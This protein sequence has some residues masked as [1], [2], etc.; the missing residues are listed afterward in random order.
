ML[1]YDMIP[2]LL[3]YDL[4]DLWWQSKHEC[5]RRAVAHLAI[6]RST[7]NDLGRFFPQLARES[8]VVA[9][10]GADSSFRPVAPEAIDAFREKYGIRKP[11]FLMVGMRGGYKGGATFLE[12]FAQLANRQEFEIICTGG[13]SQLEPDLAA[14]AD[15]HQIPIRLLQLPD[16]DDMCA[17]YA[18]ATALVYPSAYEG[19]GLPVLEAMACGCPVITCR[20]SS[21][22]EVGGEA[23][24]YVEHGDAKALT[25]ALGQVQDPVVRQRLVEAGFQQARLFS[26]KGMAEIVAGTISAAVAQIRQ[27]PKPSGVVSPPPQILSTLASSGVTLSFGSQATSVVPAPVCYVDSLRDLLQQFQNRPQDPNLFA[28][29]CR[30]R[31]MLAARLLKIAPSQLVGFHASDV[32]QAHQLLRSSGFLQFP[33]PTEDGGL[34]QNLAQRLVDPAAINV[35]LA[36]MLYRPAHR[37]PL[38]VLLDAS[39]DWFVKDHLLYVLACP[40]LFCG[41]GEAAAYAEYLQRW[42]EYLHTALAPDTPRTRELLSV[43]VQ[44]C[45]CIGAYFNNANLRSLYTHRAELIS[46]GLRRFGHR[47][48]HTFPARRAGSKIRLGILNAHWT[49]ATETYATLPLFEHLD[50]AS[51]EVTLFSLSAT[52]VPL[53]QYCRSRADHFVVLPEALD[54]QVQTL[55]QHDLDVLFF[56]TNLTAVSHALT[57]IAMHRLARVQVT[58]ICSPATTGMPMIDCFLA[59]TLTEPKPDAQA[60]YREKLCLIEGPGLCFNYGGKPGPTGANVTRAA[61]GLNDQQVLFVSGANFFKII[62]E[63]RE[64]WARIL[65]AVPDAVLLLYPFGPAWSN[66]YAVVPF[67]E[68][69]QATLQRHGVASNRVQ[70]LRPLPTSSDIA[71]FLAQCDIYLDS[72]PYAGATSLLDPLSVGLPPVAM[73]GDCLRLAQATAVLTDLGL[74]ELVAADVESYVSLAVALAQDPAR[75]HALRQAIVG[76]MN[77]S[78]PPRF[79]DSQWFSGQCGEIFR[80]LVRERGIL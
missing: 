48:D 52:N 23:V 68:A 70:F 28:S 76:R 14:P 18:G 56:G 57:L 24:I 5:I 74:P 29:L 30:E 71:Q 20:A 43:F 8:V 45:N 31:R 58:S 47:L 55:R 21:I 12:A 13:V 36:A 17:V 38:P 72:F 61:L 79:L 6:S 41:S 39:P 42:F 64:T 63:L 65:A 37:W 67:I 2:E 27:A 19:F 62:P 40:P 44:A 80:S 49:P 53:E 1:V 54:Q 11:Y 26:W 22:P 34:L 59:G 15:A 73:T 32:G 9:H 25:T 66:S 77:T 51:F 16:G 46:L 75:R 33:V 60:L 69:F 78:R 10:C 7:A 4:R 50:R 3:G 35:L